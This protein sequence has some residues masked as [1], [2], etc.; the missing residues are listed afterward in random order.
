M[1]F[2]ELGNCPQTSSSVFITFS[3]CTGN[4]NSEAISTEL[5][6]GSG[7]KQ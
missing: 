5:G 4:C 7:T 6:L 3:K 2:I 1:H